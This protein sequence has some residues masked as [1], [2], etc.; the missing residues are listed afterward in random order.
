VPRW[1][2]EARSRPG[3]VRSKHGCYAALLAVSATRP[4]AA[5]LVFYRDLPDIDFIRQILQGAEPAL[6]VMQMPRSG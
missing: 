4:W 2:S 6:R 5:A 1:G 3:S